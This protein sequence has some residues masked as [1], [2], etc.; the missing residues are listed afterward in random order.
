LSTV[1]GA[2]EDDRFGS[3]K[4][5]VRACRS[6]KGIADHNT[7]PAYPGAHQKAQELGP[8]VELDCHILQF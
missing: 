2:A 4:Q 3:I 8:A 6:L 7:T 5:T 1:A